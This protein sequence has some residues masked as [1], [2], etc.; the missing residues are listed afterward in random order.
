M[1]MRHKFELFHKLLLF[2]RVGG[3]FKFGLLCMNAEPAVG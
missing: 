1:R 3:H 2:I